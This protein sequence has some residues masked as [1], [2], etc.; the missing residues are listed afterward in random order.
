MYTQCPECHTIFALKEEHLA[1]R[2]GRVRCGKCRHIFQGD[3]YRFDT[4]P[5]ELPLPGRPASAAHAA[6]GQAPE[7]AG[8]S[9]DDSR[10]PTVTDLS[11]MESHLERR[12][13][14]GW[15]WL[16]SIAMLLLLAAQAIYVYRIELARDARVRPWMER[17]CASLRCTVPTPRDVSQI[18][19]DAEI[20]PHPQFD[21]ALLVSATLI[22]RATYTQPFPLMEVSFTNAQGVTIA[23]RT[24]TAVDYLRGSV[25]VVHG[26]SP[27]AE[28]QAKMEITQPTHSAVGYEIQLTDPH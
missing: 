26:M 18:E 9:A 10:I 6:S 22:N 16:G 28:F 8:V 24:F 14:V 12:T 5:Q 25:D 20:V 3:Q 2:Q 15:W 27:N 23:R 13:H 19:L 4:L 17:V 1:A 11:W 21:K 7:P